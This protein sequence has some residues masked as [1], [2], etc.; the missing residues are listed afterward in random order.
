[1]VKAK[2]KDI[3]QY[4]DQIAPFELQMDFDNA[5]FLVGDREAEVG[6]VMVALDVTLDVVGEARRKKCQLI[7]THHP[8][9]F[10]PLKAV[11]PADPTQAVVAELIRRNTGLICAHTNL[12]LAPGGVNDVLMD[13]LGV[14]T[15]GIL[16][17]MGDR[18]GLGDYGLGRW[19]ELPQAVEPKAFAAHVKKALGTRA[20]RAVPGTRPVKKVAVCGGAGGDMVEVAASLGMDAYVTADVKHHEFLAARALGIT[21]LDAGHYATED[22]AMDVLA[23]QLAEDFAPAGIEVLR[24][25]THKEPYFAP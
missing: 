1:M 14:K 19:G 22:P 3:Y 7:V 6:R 18:D 11:T 20:V 13:T 8:L 4:L 16:E 21:L 9:I 23:A 15:L 2:A 10:H 17:K 5:G 25:K 24:S 12:D